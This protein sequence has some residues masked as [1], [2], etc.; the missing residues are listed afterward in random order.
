MF[1]SFSIA[2]LPGFQ[3][4]CFVSGGEDGTLRVWNGLYYYD[5]IIYASKL[6]M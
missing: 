5:Y 6:C 1:S 2:L 4:S 3:G